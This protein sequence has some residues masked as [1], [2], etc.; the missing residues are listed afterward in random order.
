MAQPRPLP[1]YQSTT[2]A[3]KADLSEL[4]RK[5]VEDTLNALLAEEAD[6]PIGAERYERTTDR[7]AYRAGHYDRTLTTA[8]GN[9]T[10][11]MPKLKG[12][13]FA[14]AIVDRC[15]RRE[16]SVEEAMIEIYSPASPP[17]ASRTCP[18]PSGAPACP[19]TPHRTSTRRP[20]L[21]WRNG[22][23]GR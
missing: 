13:R 9:V 14:T 15:K 12:L 3:I 10:L 5:T 21:S 22:G 2:T 7:E 19:R 4:V 23:A 20:S 1:S 16:T 18:R 11:H 17:G 6:D 8:S